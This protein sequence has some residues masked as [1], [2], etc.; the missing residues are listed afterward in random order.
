MSDSEDPTV[1]SITEKKKAK[2]LG[3][4]FGRR[5]AHMTVLRLVHEHGED[6]ARKTLKE[7]DKRSEEDRIR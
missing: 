2:R 5:F 4:E 3:K 6:E 1:F 7:W